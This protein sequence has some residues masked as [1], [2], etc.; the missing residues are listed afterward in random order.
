MTDLELTERV[1]KWLGYDEPTTLQRYDGIKEVNIR[2]GNEWFVFDPLCD[3]NDLW[4]KVVPKLPDDAKLSYTNGMAEITTWGHFNWQGNLT[5][6]P[7]AVCELVASLE[8]E[9]V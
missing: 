9:E 4:N 2:V 8:K 6:L 3:W 5:E 7:R 1:A